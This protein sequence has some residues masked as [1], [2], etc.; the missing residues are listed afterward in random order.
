MK[1]LFSGIAVSVMVLAFCASSAVGQVIWKG[2]NAEAPVL[3]RY[4]GQ[5][6]GT[7]NVITGTNLF[8]YEGSL[9]TNTV[10]LTNTAANVCALVNAATGYGSTTNAYI[11]PWQA[12]V[13]GAVTTDT[14]GANKCGTVASNALTRGVWDNSLLWVTTTVGHYDCVVSG[15]VGGNTLGGLKIT[16][17]YGNAA[18]TGD[19]TVVVYEDSTAIYQRIFPA[20]TVVY[21]D[22]G[23][24]NHTISAAGDL[25]AAGINFQS[26][27]PIGL[28]KVGLIRA[29]MSTT[30][31]TA[32]GIGAAIS[33][34]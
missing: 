16:S 11:R 10:S 18:G 4:V 6:S 28:G 32:G 5:Q 9:S 25:P 24:T 19:C 22:A 14:L 27:L 13:W 34:P 33:Q 15:N 2:A 23:G 1:K 20:T 26:G 30:A 8:L 31:A 3:I 12:K 7:Y 17:I 21:A 29:T